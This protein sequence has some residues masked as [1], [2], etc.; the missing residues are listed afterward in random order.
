LI[1]TLSRISAPFLANNNKH[2]WSKNIL[3]ATTTSSK[4]FAPDYHNLAATTCQVRLTSACNTSNNEHM[5]PTRVAP[6]TVA[7][8]AYNEE[9]VIEQTLTS[10]ARQTMLAESVIVV[11]DCST[12]NTSRIA[13]SYKNVTVLRPPNNTGSKAGAQSYALPFI[14]TK[15]TIAIDA[16]TS[17]PH[18]AIEKMY[19]FME[20][21][22]ETAAASCYV[23]PKRVST[24]WER[25]RFVEY[26]F[27]F[28]FTKRIQELYGKPLISSGCFSIYDTREL[29]AVGGWSARTM[30]EDMDLTWTLYERGKIVRYNHDAL[31]LPLEPENL[32]MLS[33]Q[34][35]RWSHGYLQN[36]RLHWKKMKKIPVLREQVI[37]GLCDAFLGSIVLI[38]VLPLNS[39]LFHDPL[40][41]LYALLADV[42]FISIPPIVKGYKMKMVRKVLSSLPFFLLIRLVN[43]YFFYNAFISEF[44]LNK[45]LTRYEKGH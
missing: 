20:S 28:P 33:K 22:E 32:N 3:S 11:D 15:Y 37:A 24:I 18:D 16:D 29:K 41:I 6:V 43:M 40:T 35:R 25:G 13:K 42:S 17:L 31:C 10:L 44:L 26:M 2:F 4:N 12:D 7:V 27:V 9:S 1:F 34:L 30:A 23:I 21:N 8:P 38:V 14:N 19:K 5:I 39:I 45:S 36:I